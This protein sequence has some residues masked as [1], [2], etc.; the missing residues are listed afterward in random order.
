MLRVIYSRTYLAARQ[1]LLSMC[2]RI[3]GSIVP[4]S[5]GVGVEAVKIRDY[6]R[7]MDSGVTG[8]FAIVLTSK[9]QLV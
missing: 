1:A 3:N 5:A 6:T 7:M 4:F 9:S 2:S 8:V